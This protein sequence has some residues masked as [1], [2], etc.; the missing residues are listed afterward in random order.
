MLASA[1]NLMTGTP[2]SNTM[3]WH[4]VSGPHRKRPK[5]VTDSDNRTS[6]FKVK[7]IGSNNHDLHNV[8]GA[9]G[10]STLAVTNIDKDCDD[11]DV[12]N[13]V[14]GVSDIQSFRK[15]Y[16]LEKMRTKQVTF[17]VPRDQEK[18]FLDPSKW[19]VGVCCRK[20]IN[21]SPR[22]NIVKTHL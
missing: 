17:C 8:K 16:N 21:R 13:L 19:P 15:A 4:E 5:R 2:N 14:K 6:R 18:V 1:L 10:L 9:A 12:E 11:L 3:D 20:W 22:I 7:V